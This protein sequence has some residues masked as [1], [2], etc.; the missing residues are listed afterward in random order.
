V[1]YITRSFT[2]VITEC[3]SIFAYYQTSLKKFNF[4]SIKSLDLALDVL[5]GFICAAMTVAVRLLIENFW[6]GVILFPL[7]FPTVVAATLLSNWRA[8]LVTIAACQTIIWYFMMPVKNSFVL[9]NTSAA[10]SLILATVAELLLLVM[11]HKFQVSRRR[12]IELDALRIADLELAIEELDHRTMNNFQLATALLL[13]EGKRIDAREAFEAL[14][15]ASNRLHV[16][17]SVH[18]KLRHKGTDIRSRDLAALLEEILVAVRTNAKSRSE[19]SITSDLKSFNVPAE[20]AVNTRLIVNELVTN[21]LKHAFPAGKGVIH[22]TLAPHDHGY[23]LVVMDNGVG[24]TPEA[25]AGSGSRLV[26]MLANSAGGELSYG[27]GPG[28]IAILHV[29]SIERRSAAFAA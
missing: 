1:Q 24:R 8:G 19:I 23:R 9:P 17:A 26:P 20:H 22:V 4:L 28:T 18:Q 2:I 6:Q 3:T 12:I 13:I 27:D 21:A 16:L 14:E 15:R 10:V 5:I 11:V 7:V 29:P 25:N